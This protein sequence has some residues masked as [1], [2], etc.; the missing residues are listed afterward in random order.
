MVTN[1]N[2]VEKYFNLT[3]DEI[4][5]INGKDPKIKKEMK[6][7]PNIEEEKELKINEEN[8]V[9]EN[10]E[11]KVKPN[12][13]EEKELNVEPSVKEEKEVNDEPNIPICRAIKKNGLKCTK[14]A[15]NGTSLCGIHKNYKN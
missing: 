8:E 2:D 14:K 13:K 6:C 1:D 3:E 9:K 15:K 5:M 4:G 7:E 12:S 10:K 11:E